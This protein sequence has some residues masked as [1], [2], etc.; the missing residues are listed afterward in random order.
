MF[1]KAYIVIPLRDGQQ[2]VSSGP[3][4]EKS[5]IY[6][7]NL[8]K[9]QFFFH[10]EDAFTEAQHIVFTG[11]ANTSCVIL[12]TLYYIEAPP[13]STLNVSEWNEHNELIP[14]KLEDSE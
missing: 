14:V 11:G 10:I 4:Q 6:G 1:K 8:S 5:E 3:Q 13:V 9:I 12:E 2:L 7:V